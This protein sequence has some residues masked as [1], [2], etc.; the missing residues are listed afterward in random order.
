M[1]DKLVLKM[2]VCEA[3]YPGDERCFPK[4]QLWDENMDDRGPEF[5]AELV[6]EIHD[7]INH[8][9]SVVIQKREA[10]VDFTKKKNKKKE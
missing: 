10:G 9:V 6:N 1:V 4:P 5:M 2:H 8:E 3:V 7:I